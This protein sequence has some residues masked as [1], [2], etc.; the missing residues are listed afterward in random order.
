MMEIKIRTIYGS[1]KLKVV[2]AFNEWKGHVEYDVLFWD[3]VFGN[4]WRSV[5][6]LSTEMRK[7]RKMADY[8]YNEC[9]KPHVPE[10]E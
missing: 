10:N 8:L 1:D 9:S 7:S 5:G 3:G 4:K 6:R 2:R